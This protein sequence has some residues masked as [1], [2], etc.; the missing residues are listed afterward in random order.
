MAALTP[1]ASVDAL[2]GAIEKSG[3]LSADALT[4]VKDDAA[5]LN[6]PK[7][8]A[9]ELI[10]SRTLT[11]W[12]AEQ[13][14]HGYHRLT[15]GKYKLLDQLAA[16][17]TGR[18]YL[19]E[20]A[21]MGRRHALKVLAKRLASNPEA[22]KQFLDAARKACSLDHRNISHVYDV[23][24]DRL[25]H[26]VV[27]EHVEGEDLER[28]VARSGRL[29]LPQAL[30]F[31]AAAADGLAHAHAKGVVHGDLKPANLLRDQSG[32]IKILEIGQT[33]TGAPPESGEIDEAVETAAAG[34][35]IFQAPELRGESRAADVACDV[36]SLGSVFAFLLTGKPAADANAAG[37]QLTAAGDIPDAAI[38]LCRQMMAPDRGQRPTAMQEV[39]GRLT[40]VA[41]APAVKPPGKTG[42]ADGE[43]AALAA[44][45]KE[46]ATV[47]RDQTPDITVKKE[48]P[49]DKPERPAGKWKQP[50]KAKSVE[51]GKKPEDDRK[52]DDSQKPALVF[53]EAA[54]RDAEPIGAINI[55]TRGRRGKKPPP[56]Q[57]PKADATAD[58]GANAETPPA[59]TIFTPLVIAGAIGGGGVLILALIIA[60]VC[61]LVVGRGKTVAQTNK[62]KQTAAAPMAT[63][64]PAAA[65]EANPE[66]PALEKNP[67]TNPV[68]GVA[69]TP[70]STAAS[71]P[72]PAAEPKSSDT[73]A[74]A[75]TESPKSDAPEPKKESLP[76]KKPEPE[77][78]PPPKP[79]APPPAKA[80]P[81][82]APKPQPFQGFAKAVSLPELPETA[83]QPAPNALSSVAMGP[84]GIDDKA[85]LAV[86]LLTN[87]APVRGSQKKFELAPKAGGN[88]EWDVLLGAGGMNANVAA[89]S[90][91]DGKLMFQWTDEAIKQAALASH[92]S[93]CALELTSDKSRH[94]VALRTAVQGQPLIVDIEK[95][96]IGVKWNIADVP[97]PKQ[98]Q[99]EIT[100]LEGMKQ[101]KQEPKDAIAAGEQFTVWTGP[102]EKSQPLG[103]KLTTSATARSVE[104]KLQPQTKLEGEDPKLYRRKELVT[105]QQ[106]T[107][108]HLPLLEA[109]IKRIK[110]SRGST[111]NKIQ[112]ELDKKLKESRLEAAT[113]ELL[114]RSTQLDQ[115]KYLTDFNT[116]MQGGAKIHFRVFTTAGPVQIDLL[117]TEEPKNK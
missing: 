40:E 106:Q 54:P 109:E 86:N 30:E 51:D 113:K 90:V 98:L 39:L 59:K 107:A 6:D 45:K 1:V 5:R 114:Q 12:Q 73:P 50:P 36:Y 10:K 14:L 103:L 41:K 13:L 33:P 93:N 80:A 38:E 27:M 23:N 66:A 63:P 49:S 25:G 17:P 76:E 29:K 37:E 62:T 75:K 82:A 70:T 44:D 57:P 69:E 116:S 74:P 22:V 77:P 21:Q 104:I 18:I 35:A 85:A 100:S 99:I 88:R 112:A 24:Q 42:R 105:L 9:R 64:A 67:E 15:V 19:A 26:Y 87:D 115:I 72:S 110:D 16:A 83:G 3:L 117:R 68:V 31:V 7:Q 34:A 61:L 52:T 95:P 43:A 53:G 94:V 28:L 81:K 84:L 46:T 48:V 56:V 108:Q 91:K 8:L 11:K 111:N 97:I 101:A 92:L 47:K 55:K 79:A 58:A 32:T 89:L 102:T 20:H 78:T 2:L 65:D 60:L 96:N 71:I 4:K